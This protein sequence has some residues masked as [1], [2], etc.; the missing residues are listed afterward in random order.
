MSR[1]SR[2]NTG[3]CP[4]GELWSE[5]KKDTLTPRFAFRSEGFCVSF[6]A[7]RSVIPLERVFPFKSALSKYNL[8]TIH[9]TH[10]QYAVQ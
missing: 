7:F 9:C 2:F 3:F 6:S 8:H 5:S 4:Y 1:R 10:F